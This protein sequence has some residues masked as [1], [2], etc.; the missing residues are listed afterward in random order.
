VKECK[1]YLEN[2]LG[3]IDGEIDE[4]LCTD[5]M[6]HL[7]S[8]PNCRVMVDALK[9]TVVLCRDGK[10]EKLPPDIE[11]RLNAV[12]KKKWDQKFKS[13]RTK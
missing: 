10:M 1:K 8:C 4:S 11:S 12:L 7:K 9:Q 2:M 6:E 13:G 5:L 3:Y